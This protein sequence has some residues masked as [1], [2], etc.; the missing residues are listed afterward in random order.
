MNVI[1]LFLKFLAVSLADIYSDNQQ[2]IYF[3]LCLSTYASKNSGKMID[4][5][6]ECFSI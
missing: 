3:Y 1:L 2:E 4:R 6:T 5:Q